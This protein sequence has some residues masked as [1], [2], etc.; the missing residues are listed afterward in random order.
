MTQVS[1]RVV[2]NGVQETQDA[3][4][5]LAGMVRGGDL[6]YRL[7]TNLAREGER[8]LAI[9]TPRSRNKSRSASNPRTK[10]GF[11]P[12][13]RGWGTTVTDR[14]RGE[15][16]RAMITNVAS[17]NPAGAIILLALEGGAK[18]HEIDPVHAT[19]LAWRSPRR[20]R[21]FEGRFEVGGV[22]HEAQSERAGAGGVVFWPG[23]T[24]TGVLHPGHRAFSMVQK[25]FEHLERVSVPIMGIFAGEIGALWAR[26]GVP[27]GGFLSGGVSRS[28]V[29]SNP[30]NPAAR[31]STV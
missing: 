12:L 31:R 25:S 27:G 21:R 26:A 24:R 7:G 11:P 6:V 10:R 13:Y 18:P 28:P 3:I 17:E 30:L 16:Y 1:T 5:G 9:M 8:V 2:F 29:T 23:S 4:L 15:R 22:L 14:L 20:Q 19:A